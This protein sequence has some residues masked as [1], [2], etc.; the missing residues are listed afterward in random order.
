LLRATRKVEERRQPGKTC[1]AARC[2]FGRDFFMARQG[3]FG[4]GLLA[5]KRVGFCTGASFDRSFARPLREHTVD[6]LPH[7]CAG[8]KSLCAAHQKL[9]II[10]V[11]MTDVSNHGKVHR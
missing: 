5:S 7:P 4:L 1:I 2:H 6:P 8:V 10:C 3:F 9:I 11:R